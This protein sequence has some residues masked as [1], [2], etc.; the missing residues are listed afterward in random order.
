[1]GR[2]IPESAA[3]FEAF[4]NGILIV[5]LA[6]VGCSNPP[7]DT[8]EGASTADACSDA[9]GGT[10]SQS[11][12]HKLTPD[13]PAGPEDDIQGQPADQAKY[14]TCSS[15][16]TCGLAACQSAPGD[17]C[18]H[19]CLQAAST[20]MV[21][22]FTDVTKCGTHVCAKDQCAGSSAKS[23]IPECMWSRCLGFAAACSAVGNT[24]GATNCGEALDCLELCGGQMSCLRDCYSAMAPSGQAAFLTLWSCIAT[25][26]ADD[27]FVDCYD[28]ALDCGGSGAAVGSKSCLDVLQCSGACGERMTSEEFDCNSTCYSQ[29][30]PSAKLQ[31][32][33]VVDCYTGFSQ[34]QPP[35]DC[36]SILA[37]CVQPTGT[38]TCPEIDPC[39]VQCRKTGKSQGVCTFECLKQASPKESR[40]F[41]DLMLCG[42]VTC[43]QPC[44][45]SADKDC[46]A[47]C[48]LD[49]CKALNDVCLGL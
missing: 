21:S 41:L 20:E 7:D 26:D 45:G 22:A 9:S 1:M 43:G 4:C 42:S 14:K 46:V 6:T 25:S 32:K 10:S 47:T 13:W 31:F 5:L 8:K 17:D 16:W 48:R 35:G 39:T 2:R 37:D 12:C 27:P 11:P 23:C 29:G 49:K 24:K 34:G 3:S 36:A 44:K 38:L 30:S 15:L 33:Q 19:T 40:R 28:V 18:L